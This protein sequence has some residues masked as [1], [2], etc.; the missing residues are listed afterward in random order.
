MTVNFTEAAVVTGA[1]GGLGH[2]IAEQL[3]GRYGVIRI[4]KSFGHDIL[5]AEGITKTLDRYWQMDKML[6]K[7]LVNCA[8]VNTPH[9]L[10]DLTDLEFDRHMACNVRGI[11]TM[12]KVMLPFLSKGGTVLNIVSNA[13]HKPMT[14]SLAYNASKAAAAMVTKQM[15]HELWPRHQITV[16]SISPNRLAG[17]PMSKSVDAAVA[18]ARGWSPEIVTEKQKEAMPIGEETNPKDLAEFVGYLLRS[19]RRHKWLH[20][21][22]IPYGL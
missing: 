14:A 11:I 2:L 21:C 10:E 19:K 17:T 1:G 4:D 5:D 13:S 9:Y 12:V 20:G 16:F 8:G 18:E 22:D 7:L 15:A 3:E 6:P